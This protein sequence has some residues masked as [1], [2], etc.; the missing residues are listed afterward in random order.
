MSI[1]SGFGS[2]SFGGLRSARGFFRVLAFLCLLD[3]GWTPPAAADDERA[4]SGTH[5]GEE[6][7]GL[8]VRSRDQR[9]I[10]PGDPVRVLAEGGRWIRHTFVSASPTELVVSPFL[11][12]DTAIRLP[13]GETR[14]AVQTGSVSHT[15]MGLTIGAG[16]G[17]L[18]GAVTSGYDSDEDALV[19]TSGTGNAVFGMMLFGL[20]G[21]VLGSV[22]RTPVWE[23]VEYAGDG[24]AAFPGISDP[25][26]FEI[27]LVSL[28]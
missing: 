17:L 5:A 20:I 2:T 8:E 4:A 13:R 7:R 9:T 22:V 12:A 25:V 26:E 23:E 14:L 21:G 10:E 16:F 18:L 6:R 28:P 24:T 15:G 19:E 3:A 1:G 11:Y 27:V